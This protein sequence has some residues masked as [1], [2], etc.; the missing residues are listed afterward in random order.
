[1]GG[2]RRHAQAGFVSG[3]CVDGV[4]VD[5][6]KCLLLCLKR[7]GAEQFQ[8]YHHFEQF[9]GCMVKK[10]LAQ[11]LQASLVMKGV[12]RAVAAAESSWTQHAQVLSFDGM[13]KP[14]DSTIFLE[15]MGNPPGHA[16][17][18]CAVLWRVAMV[19]AV[20]CCRS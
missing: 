18:C 17:L 6:Y 5:L 15:I 9:L 7:L 2:V 3:P 4:P 1:M 19:C 14:A 11:V 16:V 20:C 12:E 10:F 8:H 13:A